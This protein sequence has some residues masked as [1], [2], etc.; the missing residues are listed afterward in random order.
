M[1]RIKAEVHDDNHTHTVPFEAEGWFQSAS[2]DD[3]RG[4]A[5]AGWT[6]C[7][8]SDDIANTSDSEAVRKFFDDLNIAHSFFPHGLGYEVVVD[9]ADALDFLA[10]ERPDLFAELTK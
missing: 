9:E 2:D 1:P 5:K 6:G 10:M 8:L 7:S 3:I 4:L